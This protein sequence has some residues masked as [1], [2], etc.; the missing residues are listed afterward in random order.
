MKIHKTL[1]GL[2]TALL[3]LLALHLS[4]RA[5]GFAMY[6]VLERQTAEDEV[7]TG[8]FASACFTMTRR[9]SVDTVFIGNSHQYCSVDVTLLNREYGFNSILLASSGQDLEMSC[10]AALA[11]IELQHPKTIV[12]EMMGATPGVNPGDIRR[13]E[14]LDNLPNW[15]RAK[16]LAVRALGDAPY[17]RYYPLTGMHN[18]WFLVRGEDFR[19]PVNPLAGERLRFLYTKVTP[20]EPW[21]LIPREQTAPMEE[22]AAEWLDRIVA[23]CAENGIELI[24]YT[25]PYDAPEDEQAI[26]NGLNDYAREHGLRYRNMMYDME[27]V[28]LDPASDFVDEG[29]VNCSG[30]EKL[31]RF[32]AETLL[33]EET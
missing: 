3:F 4:A 30:Q 21:E 5:L 24:L 18:S 29:H 11:A 23:L 8:D 22:K 2:G 31:T 15:S 17:L 10:Y 13:A 7:W 32:L 27:A 28:G 25:A 9:N 19:L 16:Y 6:S 33:G 20:L 12:L 14:L 26:F 1:R